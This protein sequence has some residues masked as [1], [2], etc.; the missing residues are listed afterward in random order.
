MTT[1][2]LT[3]DDAAAAK[4]R[5][6]AQRRQSS[7]EDL[8]QRFVVNLGQEENGDG[9]AELRESAAQKLI[10]SFQQLSRPLGGKGYHSRDELYER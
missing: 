6:A 2:V 10:V 1:L 5:L 8:V 7:L 4:A 9:A 3:L